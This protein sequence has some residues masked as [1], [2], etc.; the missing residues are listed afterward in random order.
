[1]A[2]GSIDH[3]LTVRAPGSRR[4]WARWLSS[5]Q[6]F[7]FRAS[8]SYHLK[9]PLLIVVSCLLRV[10]LLP[11]ALTAR[12][13]SPLSRRLFALRLGSHRCCQASRLTASPVT[14]VAEEAGDT[15][16]RAP[17]RCT[18][19]RIRNQQGSADKAARV[20][21]CKTIFT[22][23]SSHRAR[24]IVDTNASCPDVSGP[25]TIAL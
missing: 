2:L 11:F 5:L 8:S 7:S 3:R 17:P 1:M 23:D 10:S 13:A 14:I 12:D 21:F 4:A 24:N 16:T 22:G 20:E 9:E 25:Q 19:D 6:L 15:R 18:V